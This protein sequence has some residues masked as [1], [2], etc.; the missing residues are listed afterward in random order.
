MTTPTPDS[1]STLSWLTR[2]RRWLLRFEGMEPADVETEYLRSLFRNYLSN[3]PLA[4]FTTLFLYNAAPILP[5]GNAAFVWVVCNVLFHTLRTLAGIA[6]MR[7]VNLNSHELRLW[8]FLSVFLQ[9]VDGLLMV[10]LALAIYPTI[11]PL[12]QSALLMASL[13][14]VG[15]TASSF[16]W[17]WWSMAVYVP[18][19]YLSFAWA[20]WTL[21]HAYAKP[22]A[23]LV[24]VFFILYLFYARN[25]RDFVAQ[26]MDLGRRNGELAR[27]NGEL[28]RELRVKNDELQE[29]ATARSRL[30]ATVSH[31]LRQPAHAIG[32]LCERAL[33]E[34]NPSALKESLGDL[35]EL[36]QSLSASLSTLMDL[37]RLDAGLVT[38][39]QAATPLSQVLLRLDAEFSASARHKGLEFVLSQ[40]THWVQ[41]DPDL[42]HGILAN[43]VSNA[44]KYTRQGRVHVLVSESGEFV[45]VSVRDSGDG[46]H[47]DKLELI[48]KE[49]VRLDASESGTEGLGLGLSIVRRYASLLKHELTVD[50]EPK[51]G[52]CFSITLPLTSAD[53]QQ[54]ETHANARNLAIK[55][56]RLLGLRVLVIDNVDMLLSNMSKT[57]GTWGCHVHSA[58]N[59]TEALQVAEANRLDMVISDFHLGDREPDGLALIT[60]MRSLSGLQTQTLP[61]ILMTGD[62]SSQL[63]NDAL[64]RK[65]RLLH[66][67]VR[68]ALLQNCMLQL[69]SQAEAQTQ[70]QPELPIA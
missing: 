36:S 66:K 23:L 39:H 17:R 18:P 70:A 34:A 59:I 57:L 53:R 3:S 52:S 61:A 46:I 2:W 9:M 22:V 14:I 37:T 51:R 5:P 26:A 20:T 56:D 30:L 64:R 47:K 28:A 24:L 6:Y 41:S 42:L 1:I 38:V 19:T 45:T 8:G 40:S 43:L 44:I 48:F 27:G 12:G 11:D 29:V 54:S 62:V 58:H 16:A 67:P 49:F 60:A 4:I 69:L 7:L 55:D 31:D 63:E 21:E 35:N 13:I 10:T 32:L 68:P 50:S 65:V 15:A 33:S 25:H